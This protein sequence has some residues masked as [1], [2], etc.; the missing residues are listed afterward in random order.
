MK[1][2]PPEPVVQAL[3]ALILLQMV[4]SLISYNM[5]GIMIWNVVPLPGEDSTYKCPE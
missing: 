4:A 1:L 3:E 2:K 5:P